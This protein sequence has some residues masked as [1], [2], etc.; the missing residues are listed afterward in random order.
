VKHNVEG[1][2]N[3]YKAQ[4]MARGFSQIHGF[5]FDKMYMNVTKFMSIRTIFMLGTILDLEIHQVD[6]K[7]AFFNGE[8][9]KG[10]YMMKPKRFT[11]SKTK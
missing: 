5:D 8:L 7:C 9:S 3:C 10:I 1:G 4:L 6:V 2:N 11:I